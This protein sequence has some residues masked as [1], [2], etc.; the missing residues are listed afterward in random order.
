MKE[1][2]FCAQLSILEVG[3]NRKVILVEQKQ[4]EIIAVHLLI[5]VPLKMFSIHMDVRGLFLLSFNRHS[6]RRLPLS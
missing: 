4:C 2:R 3:G 5:T 1:V 6:E